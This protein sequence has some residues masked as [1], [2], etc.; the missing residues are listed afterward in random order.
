MCWLALTEIGGNAATPTTSQV[1]KWADG[2]AGWPG[3]YTNWRSGEPNNHDGDDE[4]YSFLNL[5]V[6]GHDQVFDGTWFD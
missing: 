2:S 6:T 1:W 4:R 3:G 5:D